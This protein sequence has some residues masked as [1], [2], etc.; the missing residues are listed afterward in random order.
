MRSI[1]G[2]TIRA[3]E[4]E[5]GDITLVDEEQSDPGHTLVFG[6]YTRSEFGKFYP[7]NTAPFESESFEI[8]QGRNF[9]ATFRFNL[10]SFAK[11]TRPMPPSPNFSIIS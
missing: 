1:I 2:K 11:Y 4:A 7:A 9:K 5:Q 8:C 6:A 10:V 3:L